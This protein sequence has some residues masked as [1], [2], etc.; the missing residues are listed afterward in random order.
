MCGISG[1]HFFNSKKTSFKTWETEMLVNELLLGIEHRGE[2]ATGIATIR[3]NGDI[4]IE[5]AD[6]EAKEFVKHRTSLNKRIKTI[7]LHTRYATKGHQSNNLNNHP[8]INNNAVITHNGHIRNDDDLFFSNKDL[9][10]TAEVDSEAIAALFNKYGVEKAHLAL[11]EL[12]GG[13][14]IAAI[15][16]RIPTALVLAKGKSSPLAYYKND[17]FIIWASESKVIQDALSKIKPEYDLKIT[18]LDFLAEGEILYMDHGKIENLNFKVKETPFVYKYPASAVT[19]YKKRHFW[20]DW[21]TD[22]K[23]EK[24]VVPKNVIPRAGSYEIRVDGRKITYRCCFKCGIASNEDF[25]RGYDGGFWC[26]VCLEDELDWTDDLSVSATKEMEEE[27][28]IL[29][30]FERIQDKNSFAGEHM[31]ICEKIGR[32]AGLSKGFVDYILFECEELMDGE[33]EN[34]VINDLY[35]QLAELYDAEVGAM[36]GDDIE[37]AESEEKLK[38]EI[39][40]IKG[41]EQQFIGL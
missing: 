14:A 36:F 6:I 38:T 15:D 30:E 7:L 19:P 10:R 9:N 12:E 1:V 29:K 39:V 3:G 40:K 37:K 8:V 5:K 17:N 41:N 28:Q 2:D 20:N 22:D 26:D 4:W 24:V 25:L 34:P 11:Q 18:D 13:F 27:N 31:E 33:I 16:Q 32:L 21:D 23:D 35:E